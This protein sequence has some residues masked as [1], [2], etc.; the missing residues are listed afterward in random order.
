MKTNG[1]EVSDQTLAEIKKLAK[2]REIIIFTDPD[3]NGERI[4]R[5]VT[6]AAPNAKQVL[7]L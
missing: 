4:R 3:Y 5:L 6:N 1:S 7:S 2:T